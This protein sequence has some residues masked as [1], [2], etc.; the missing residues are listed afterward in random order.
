MYRSIEIHMNYGGS[1][2]E[3]RGWTEAFPDVN[4]PHWPAM[5]TNKH[6]EFAHSVSISGLSTIHLH[7]QLETHSKVSHEV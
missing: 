6:K 2:S 3:M 4:P 7:T 1:L 5:D